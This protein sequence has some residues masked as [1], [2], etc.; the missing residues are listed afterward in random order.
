MKQCKS[1]G[2]FKH[3]I[4]GCQKCPLGASRKNFVFGSGN[5]IADLMIIGEAPGADEDLQ[6]EPFV[7]RAGQL[8]KHIMPLNSIEKMCL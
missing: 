7:G 5:P 1:L 3:L 8:H 4:S 6:G 2:E